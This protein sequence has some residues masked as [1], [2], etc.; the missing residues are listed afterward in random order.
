M[1]ILFAVADYNYESN[2]LFVGEMVK[3]NRFP[4][5]DALQFVKVRI[6]EADNAEFNE[7][8]FLGSRQYCHC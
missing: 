8:R 3:F 4:K 1:F 2:V 5:S 7:I 6:S